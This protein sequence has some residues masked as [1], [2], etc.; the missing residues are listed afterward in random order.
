MKN[1]TILL[2][3]ISFSA[4]GQMTIDFEV[5]GQSLINF[6]LSGTTFT[7]ENIVMN[8]G[9]NTISI[10]AT[11]S[12]GQDSKSTLVISRYT[13]PAEKEKNSETDDKKSKKEKKRKSSEKGKGVRKSKQKNRKAD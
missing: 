10:T 7:A 3:A 4:F 5:N 2:I 11:N 6:Q 13:P 8:I 9:N 12:A 1:I